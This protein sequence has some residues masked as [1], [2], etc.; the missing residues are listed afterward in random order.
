MKAKIEPGVKERIK[1]ILVCVL[2]VMIPLLLYLVSY[3]VNGKGIAC[4][5]HATTGL[6]CP[7]CGMTRMVLAFFKGDI[8]QSFR[9]NPY[10]FVSIPLIALIGVI[11]SVKYILYNYIYEHIDVVLISYVISIIIFGVIRN[12]SIFSWLAPTVI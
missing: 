11:W 5:I 2:A 8:Y 1:P 10:M 9:Y 12:I 3:L 4:T 7:G 6:N